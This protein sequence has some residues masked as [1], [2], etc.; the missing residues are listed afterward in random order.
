MK[1]DLKFCEEHCCCSLIYLF[2]RNIQ[3]KWT[4]PARHWGKA[5]NQFA[6]LYSDR[7]P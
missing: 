5:L 1:N 6:I 2:L 7:M 3:K 4:M